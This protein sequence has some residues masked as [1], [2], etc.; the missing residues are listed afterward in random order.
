[1][2]LLALLLGV[3]RAFSLPGRDERELIARV[4]A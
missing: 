3:C 2:L 1:M 4:C